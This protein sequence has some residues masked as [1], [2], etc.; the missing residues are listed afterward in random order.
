MST[1]IFFLLLQPCILW[2][3]QS[4]VSKQEAM[5]F[6]LYPELLSVWII[7]LVRSGPL[8]VLNTI[9]IWFSNL[10]EQ[11][12]FLKYMFFLHVYKIILLEKVILIYCHRLFVKKENFHVVTYS[13]KTSVSSSVASHLSFNKV[14]CGLSLEEFRE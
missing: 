8:R 1:N 9:W 7:I 13:H 5:S 10:L 6:S 14:N 4:V 3:M 12:E 11:V 2:D